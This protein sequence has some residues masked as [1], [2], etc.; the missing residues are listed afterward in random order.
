M[1]N[2]KKWAGAFLALALTAG[3]LAGC[4]GEKAP[5]S[6]QASSQTSP[7]ASSQAE[8]SSAQTS[9]TAS[10]DDYDYGSGLTENGF[11]EGVTALDY[12]TLPDYRSMELPQDVLAVSD[13]DLQKKLDSMTSAYSSTVQVKDRAVEDGDTVNIDYVGSV[14]GEEFAGGSTGGS[15][16]TVTIGVT[17]Y[18]D[19]FL[20]QLI[21]HTPGETFDVNVTFPTPYSNNTDLSGKDAVF[22]TTINYIEESQSP[23]LTDEF[24]AEHWKDSEGWSTVEEMKDGVRE[25]LKREAVVNYLWEQL[26]SQ[27]KVSEVPQAVSQYHL[28]NMKHYYV[29]LASQYSMELEDFLSQSVGVE[30]MDALV[31][32]NQSMVDDNA[33]SSLILQ[34][35]CEDMDFSVSEEELDAYIK[36]SLDVTDYSD[37]EDFYGKPYL[38]L[39]ARE[40]LVKEE[41]G[42]LRLNG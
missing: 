23:E 5:E 12:V 36:D 32:K 27:S 38:Y 30:D 18:I 31:E 8:D 16:T 29:L 24:V 15:G 42:S 17:S 33:K 2:W 37:V 10:Q 9:S 21:G 35:L 39:L 11:F 19:D 26:S 6:S 4:S 13:E 34:A 41:L 28:E 25:Q 3:T 7:A 40:Y 20:E 14:D 1:Q 22:V